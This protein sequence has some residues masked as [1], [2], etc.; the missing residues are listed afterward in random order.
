MAVKFTYNMSLTDIDAGTVA[1]GKQ[2]KSVRERIH[3][4][5]VSIL[6]NWHQHG[7]ANVAAQKA[8]NLLKAADAAHAQ[9]LVNW[10][11]VYGKLEFNA[12]EGF[13]Y[14]ET[15]ISLDT[16]KAAKAETCFDLTPDQ[17]PKAF[18]DIA[19]LNKLMQK[20]VART[21]SKKKTDE[22]VIHVDMWKE[23][24]SIMQKYSAE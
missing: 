19:E 4:L 2:V 1:V 11:A 15:K 6:A 22:D 24:H 10:F 13:K 7:A 17:P 21:Q 5:A 16:V 14:T 18:N 23:I 8:S 20:A 9:K 12:E 3:Y